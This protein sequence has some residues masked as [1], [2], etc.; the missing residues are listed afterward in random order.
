MNQTHGGHCLA[1]KS[2]TVSHFQGILLECLGGE[3]VKLS[4]VQGDSAGGIVVLRIGN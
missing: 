3:Q 1:S 4:E 2:F